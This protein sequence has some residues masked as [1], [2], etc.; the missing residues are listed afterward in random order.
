[1]WQ[2]FNLYTKDYIDNVT[3]QWAHSHF[4]GQLSTTDIRNKRIAF[5]HYPN[6]F[7]C[8]NT[9]AAVTFQSS[10]STIFTVFFAYSLYYYLSVGFAYPLYYN[11]FFF[12]YSLYSIYPLVSRIRCTLFIRFF[13]VSVVLY[14][15]VFFAY[16]LY[17]IYPL[18]SRIRCTLFIRWFRVSVVLYL[19]VGFAYPLY[20]IYPLVSRMYPLY[21]IRIKFNTPATPWNLIPIVRAITA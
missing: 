19:S 16:S 8:T 9:I 2:P 1:L 4:N 6:L 10:N 18:V 15:S 21:Y 7:R 14:L 20:S 12:A 5:A 13:R 11:Q 3:F 17:Y